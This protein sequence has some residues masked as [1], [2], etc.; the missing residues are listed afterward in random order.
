MVNTFRRNI[1]LGLGISLAVLIISS[2]ASYISIRKLLESDYWVDHTFQVIQELDN[3]I[4]RLKDAETGQRGFL[5][6][7]DPVFL[8]PYNGSKEDIGDLIDHAQLLTTDN[9]VQ[10]KDFPYLRELIEN[11]YV[12]INTTI[13]DR[14]RG[15]PVTERKLLEGKAIMDHI[16]S[17]IR[18]MEQRERQL[19]VSRT[20][21][22]DTFAT[23]TPVLI[24]L[25]SFIAVIITFAFY[26]RMKNNMA[27]NE[28]LQEILEQKEEMTEKNIKVISDLAEQI[29]K[30][31][32]DV[33]IRDSDFE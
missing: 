21:K 30:G 22:M 8:E 33:R 26:R 14:K 16:R 1:R 19:L 5:L 11:K 6:T 20:S 28:R 7:A 15:I 23:F 18:V 17:L 2:A 10:Q 4:S 32:Y 13:A 29:S 31:N 12:F 3:I 9:Q 27:E 24:L 25:A